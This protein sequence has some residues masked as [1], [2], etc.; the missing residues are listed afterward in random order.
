MRK[1][2]ERCVKS[3]SQERGRIGQ[4]GQ[5]QESFMRQ[6]DTRE[7]KSE[8]ELSRYLRKSEGIGRARIACASRNGLG[9]RLRVEVF[10]SRF[11]FGA[12]GLNL[13]YN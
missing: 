1:V 12:E 13:F 6:S 5:R 9:S 8:R 10:G 2:R 11:G 3:Y 7:S 4:R